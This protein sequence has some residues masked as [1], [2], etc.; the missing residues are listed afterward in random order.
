MKQSTS[1]WFS[2]LLRSGVTF[3]PIMPNE[4]L[5][6]ASALSLKKYSSLHQPKQGLATIVTFH[7][8]MSLTI[9]LKRQPCSTLYMD[10]KWA[11]H[12]ARHLKAFVWANCGLAYFGAKQACSSL[13]T[14]LS[15]PV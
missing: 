4:V 15:F 14:V 6:I 11:I 9:E 7:T 13:E 8:G 12:L 2:L 1:D 5:Q 10:L 3:I